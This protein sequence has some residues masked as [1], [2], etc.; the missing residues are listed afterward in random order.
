MQNPYEIGPSIASQR[1]HRRK[2]ATEQLKNLT[3]AGSQT[4][5]LGISSTEALP[6][7]LRVPVGGTSGMLLWQT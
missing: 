1:P 3:L 5:V 4:Q 7:N 2:N 6:T